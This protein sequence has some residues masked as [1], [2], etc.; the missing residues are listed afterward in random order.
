MSILQT[1]CHIFRFQIFQN[2]EIQ[3]KKKKKKCY[4]FKSKHAT[5]IDNQ[6]AKVYGSVEKSAYTLLQQIHAHNYAPLHMLDSIIH[7]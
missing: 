6:L 2:N 5:R 7:M 3:K 1:N 4:E